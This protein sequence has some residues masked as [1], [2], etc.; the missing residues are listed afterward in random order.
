MSSTVRFPVPLQP[1]RPY[2]RLWAAIALLAFLIA[3]PISVAV[4][5]EKLHQDHTMSA[6]QSDLGFYHG[7][8]VVRAGDRW[9]EVLTL[10]PQPSGP[11]ATVGVRDG[12]IVADYSVK[13]FY[14]LLEEY[15][16]E[17]VQFYVLNGGDGPPLKER[18]RR[19]ISIRVPHA[20]GP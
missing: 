12:D 3:L 15:R 11:F 4:I 1:G 18:A 13:R 19:V 10:L 16:G 20:A 14:K 8:P 2:R 17:R 6:L 9:R 7:S 5:D